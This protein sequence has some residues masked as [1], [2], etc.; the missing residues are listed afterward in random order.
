MVI[1][2]IVVCWRRQRNQLVVYCGVDCVL[3]LRQ[4]T[5]LQLCSVYACVGQAGLA[6]PVLSTSSAAVSESSVT[7]MF[8]ADGIIDT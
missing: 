4:L 5:A 3:T 2:S 8:I 7:N 6:E 1:I